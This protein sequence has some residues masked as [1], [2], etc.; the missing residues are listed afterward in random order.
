MFKITLN[1]DDLKQSII[2]TNIDYLK[3]P[4]FLCVVGSHLYGTADEDSDM[5]IRGFSFL[6]KEF[7]LGIKKF[8]QHQNLTDKDD[9]VVWS[10]EKYTKM[11]LNGSTIAFE[12]LFCPD[13]KIIRC[14]PLAYN[15][16]RHKQVF[17][18]Q[19]V[20]KSI[21][22]YAQNEWRKVLGETTRDLGAKRKEHIEQKGYSY[23]NAYHALRI[24]DSGI[25]LAVYG[26]I[27]FPTQ[28]RGFLRAVKTGDVKFGDVEPLYTRSLSKLETLLS[29]VTRKQDVDY[30]NDM[31]VKLNLKRILTDLIELDFGGRNDERS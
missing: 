25:E 17:I 7:L 12:M 6:P 14:S 11:L 19:R 30:I 2:H 5:D 10:V 8:E 13:S 4:D 3:N 20:I 28:G 9:V 1:K 21:L 26:M 22:G 31:L 29:S 16:L 15:L 23:K 27:T 24:L 18:S